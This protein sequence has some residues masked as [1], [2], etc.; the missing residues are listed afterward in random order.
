MACSEQKTRCFPTIKQ[1][2]GLIILFVVLRLLYY[3]VSDGFAI[4]KIENTFP[5]RTEWHL[6]PPN[7]LQMEKISAICAQDFHYLGKG[8]QVYAFKST[9]GN[10]VLKLLKCYHLTPVNWLKAI[11]LPEHFAYVRDDAVDRRQKKIED[12]LAS[13]KVAAELLRE[14]CGLVYMQI[15]PSDQFQVPLTL[16]DKLG[17]RLSINLAH[18][19]F[20]LQ[21]KADLVFPKITNWLATGDTQSVRLALE[22]IAALIVKRSKKGIQDQDPDLH[23]NAGLIGTSAIF[24]DLGSFHINQNVCEE[25][26]YMRDLYKISRRLYEW[27][28]KEHPESAIIFNNILKN[29]AKSSWQK[30][31]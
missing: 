8:S 31:E 22:S 27:L 6:S 2:L 21:R 12:S 30:P 26:T 3:W 14:E 19:G 16:I 24:I 13:Y 10:Y 20:I 7:Q 5:T 28:K 18:F 17:R 9:D 23:K 11:P 25:A 15:L 1:L 4:Y 29:A